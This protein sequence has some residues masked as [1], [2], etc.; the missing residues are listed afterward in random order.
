MSTQ[1]LSELF[2]LQGKVAVVVGGTGVLCG[3]MAQGMWRAGAKVALVGRSE[4]KAQAHF[5]EWGAAEGETL[6]VRA[7]VTS[8][9]D[10]EAVIPEV[11][12]TLGPVDIWV[13]GAGINSATPYLDIEDEEFDRIVT[14]NLKAVHLG[15]QIIAKHWIGQGRGGSIINMSSMS[16]IRPLSRV[17]TYSLTKGAVWNLTQ[18]LACE[19]A[20]QGIRVNALCPGFFPAEQNRK[21][22]DA[23]RVESIMNATPMRRFGEKEELIAATLLLASD[24]A[25]GFITGSNLVVDGGFAAKAI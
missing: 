5:K 18:N 6:F 3:A 4:E 1:F 13:N 22:L 24:A 8:R 16:A 14:T 20:Q 11:E 17:F 9:S 7:D 15:C 21:I 19:W 10:M 2:G 25:G 23:S 12:N